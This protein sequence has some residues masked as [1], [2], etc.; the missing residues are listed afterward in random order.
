MLFQRILTISPPRKTQAARREASFPGVFSWARTRLGGSKSRAAFFA[1]G[2]PLRADTVLRAGQ[3]LEVRMDNGGVQAAPADSGLDGLPP[4]FI[5]Y[6]DE[7]MIVVSKGRAAGYA[8]LRPHPH[9]HAPRTGLPSCSVRT[10][11]RLI[12]TPSSAG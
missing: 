10:R 7:D 2:K 6:I 11:R 4:S 3:L 1:T 9:R 8:P 5:R 12:I